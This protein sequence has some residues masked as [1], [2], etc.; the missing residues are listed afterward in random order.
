[1]I[2][3]GSTDRRIGTLELISGYRAIYPL[4]WLSE[5]DNGTSQGE[6]LAYLN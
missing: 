4:R 1:M 6:M 2:D 3:G 5:P